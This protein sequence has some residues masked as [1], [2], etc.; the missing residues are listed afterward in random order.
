[1]YN[2]NLLT[3]LVSV[4]CRLIVLDSSHGACR[5]AREQLE[6]IHAKHYGKVEVIVGNIA[7]YESAMYLLEGD[8]KPDALKVN[9]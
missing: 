1:M 2:L 8:A 6:R 5:P 3:T 4:G 9:S 7:S